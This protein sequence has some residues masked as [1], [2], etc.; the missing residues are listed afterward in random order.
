[1]DPRSE[2]GERKGMSRYCDHLEARIKDLEGA[3][4][5]AASDEREACAKLILSLPP[6]FGDKN[7]NDVA[8]MIRARSALTGKE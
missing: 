1:M 3:L 5:N 8:E 2:E 4:A 6:G 7:R